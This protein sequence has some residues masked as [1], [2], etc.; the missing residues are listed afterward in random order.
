MKYLYK[1]PHRAYPYAD[2]IETSRQR[3]RQESEYELLDTG[4][5]DEDRY[6]DVF[7]EYSKTG[8]DDLLIRISVS[9]RGPEEATVHV[10]PTLLFRNTWSWSGGGVNRTSAVGA[11]RKVF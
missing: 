4:I 10:L 7:V 5:F 11:W 3:S 8:P 2:L 9:N 1:Y 6:F